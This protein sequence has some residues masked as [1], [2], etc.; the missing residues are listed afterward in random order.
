M[1]V[2]VVDGWFSMDLWSMP[3]LPLTPEPLDTKEA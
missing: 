1:S 2:N 3:A